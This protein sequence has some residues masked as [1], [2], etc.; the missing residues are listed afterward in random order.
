MKNL[1][2][3]VNY[4]NRMVNIDTP[5]YK[6]KNAF[7]YCNIKNLY[8]TIHGGVIQVNNPDLEKNLI[9]MCNKISDA[10]Y[11]FVEKSKI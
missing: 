4:C 10:I 5:N 3:N 9:L 7:S 2:F 6:D 8:T 11:E 1:Q